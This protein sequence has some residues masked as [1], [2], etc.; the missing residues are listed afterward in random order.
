[1]FGGCPESCELLCNQLQDVGD[2]ELLAALAR[3]RGDVHKAPRVVGRD[4]GAPSLGDCVQLPSREPVGDTRPLQAEAAAEAAAVGDVRQV[5]DLVAGES[6]V[7]APKHEAEGVT[8]R[9]SEFRRLSASD[10]VNLWAVV[11]SPAFAAIRPQHHCSLGNP[12][13]KPA[14]VAIRSSATAASGHTRS[15]RHEAKMV[16]GSPSTSWSWYRSR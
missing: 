6:M 14:A 13:L 11:K 2:A 15:A 1:M 3:R 8:I 9:P 10:V 5:D 4:H 7:K 12:T 16:S